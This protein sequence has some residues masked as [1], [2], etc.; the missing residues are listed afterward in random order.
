M[1]DTPITMSALRAAIETACESDDVSNLPADIGM[2]NP[3]HT[4]KTLQAC[5]RYS[6]KQNCPKVMEYLIEQGADVTQLPGETIVDSVY[7]V[8]PSREVLE[9]LVEHGWD[10]NNRGPWLSGT[11]LLWFVVG[12]VDLV[13]WCLD[14][15]ADV[16]PPD[17]TPPTAVKIRKPILQ[18]AA[19][20]DNIETFEIL[21]ARGAPLT[22]TILPSAVMLASSRAPDR[23][24]EPSAHFQ[25]SLNM[26]RHLVDV[27][28]CDV[29]AAS[30]GPNYGSGSMCSTP[31]CWI[32]CHAAGNIDATQLICLLLE[33]GGDPYLTGPT[34]GSQK[35]PS[36]YEAA[37]K[38][39]NA[40]F[41]HV[42]ETWKM[43]NKGQTA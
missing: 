35:I 2:T 40:L 23:G 19:L 18:C 33:R 12:D 1:T 3:Q 8:L 28:G 17:D 20:S 16:D 7:E 5:V 6:A 36:A 24:E 15:G 30:H 27:V 26:I 11:P 4:Q 38:R 31:L 42:V 37:V 34:I 21:R 32:A 22:Y 43:Q 10:V 29:N 9:I 41:I 14:H 25:S 13:H 39:N